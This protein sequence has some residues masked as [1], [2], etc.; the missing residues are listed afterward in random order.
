MTGRMDWRRARHWRIR[1]HKAGELVILPNGSRTPLT[2]TD[3]LQH[4]QT[5]CSAALEVLLIAGAEL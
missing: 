2:H 5:N 4:T 3:K 1:E